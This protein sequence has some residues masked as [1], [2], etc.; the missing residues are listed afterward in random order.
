MS[1][2][3]QASEPY[4]INGVRFQST[5]LNAF[6]QFHVLRRLGPLLA[7]VGP[8]FLAPNASINLDDLT[9]MGPALEALS[10][11]SEEDCDYVIQQCLSVTK[12][13]QDP[14]LWVNVWNSQA[15]LLQFADLDLAS[16]MQIT[17]H[18]LGESLASFSQGGGLNFAVPSPQQDV[19]MNPSPY[20][21]VRIS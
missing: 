11:M 14:G 10:S 7:K 4:E 17:V 1:A 16:M 20:P 2:S 13:Y 3:V 15:K 5:R 18:V 21:K 12:R 19:P 8:V 6:I 9:M